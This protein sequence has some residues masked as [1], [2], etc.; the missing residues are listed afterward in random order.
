MKKITLCGSI[1]I[2]LLTITC[3]PPKTE[4]KTIREKHN[5]IILLDLSDRLIVQPNQPE[6]DKDIV[7]SLFT[8]FEERV[9]HNLY[10]RSRDEIKVVI[11]PQRGSGI[12]NEVFE[13]R[14]YVNMGSIPNMLRRSKEVERRDNFTAALN[15]LYKKAVFSNNPQ[16]Y[17]GAD[18]WKYFYEDLEGDI[19]EDTLT[20]N[21]LF[22]L[23]DGYPIVGHDRNKLEQVNKKFP[24]L[25]IILLEAS[26]RDKDLEWDHIMD[27]WT[28][29]L[30]SMDVKEYTFVKRKAI[31]KEIEQV[32]SLV[33][34]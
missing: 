21:F 7:T 23:T 22:I 10:V 14:M 6:R 31:T 25:E 19:S 26:P 30:N 27:M 33:G 11:A 15:D 5:Y 28:T 4:K 17:Y 24:G 9:K 2:V 12:R 13:D 20:R 32:R 16:D 29:W 3:A 8:L 34:S 18:I 1:V